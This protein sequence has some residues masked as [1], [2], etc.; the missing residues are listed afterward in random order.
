MSKY[1]KEGKY[2]YECKSSPTDESLGNSI[3]SNSLKKWVRD[4][5]NLLEERQPSGFRYIFPVNNLNGECIKILDQLKS[6]FPEVDIRYFDCKAVAVLLS[7]L[8]STGRSP[9]LVEYINQNRFN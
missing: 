1:Y 2:I 8:E 7:Q 4:L 6:D 5:R 9:S 3:N